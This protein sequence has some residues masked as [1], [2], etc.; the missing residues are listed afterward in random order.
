MN[1]TAIVFANGLHSNTKLLSIFEKTFLFW[2]IYP[3]LV[4]LYTHPIQY[5]LAI[6][7]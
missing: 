6:K 7:V 1:S 5:M 4:F 2:F 3:F